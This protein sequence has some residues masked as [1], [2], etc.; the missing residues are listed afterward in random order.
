MIYSFFFL[1]Y[2]LV[3]EVVGGPQ[4][5]PLGIGFHESIDLTVDVVQCVPIGMSLIS[6]DSGSL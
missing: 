1:F 2:L 6:Y 5:Q 3:F 4:F